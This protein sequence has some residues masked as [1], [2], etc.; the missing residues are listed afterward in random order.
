MRNLLTVLVCL[1]T[2]GMFAQQPPGTE[3][4][5]FNLTKKKG[6]I[7]LTNPINITNRQGYDNQP[8]FHP[9]KPLLYYASADSEGRTDIIEYNYVAN[10]TRRL[11]ET[12]EREYS[13]TVTPDGQFISCIIQRDNGAQDLGKYPIEGGAPQVLI[14]NLTV[15]Y[16]AWVDD[17]RVITFIL[18]EPFS[19]QLVDTR[20]GKTTVLAENIGRSLHKIPKQNAMSFVQQLPDKSWAIKK[21]STKDLSIT[22]L[23][24]VNAE[25]EPL[26]T[27]ISDGTLLRSTDV[28]I[29]AINPGKDKSWSKVEI[30][31][32]MK[33]I[34]RMAVN[35]QGDKVAVVVSE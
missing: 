15:G 28:E 26:L 5:L 22:N 18:P 30:Q 27:W 6:V 2:T 21:L 9:E 33:G 3:I 7:S 25:R 10:T 13:P 31:S 12:P 17:A 11:T 19:L 23:V 1:T 29:N 20:T 35:S 14:N 8:Y 24:A 16:H 4:Y 34:S 32:A